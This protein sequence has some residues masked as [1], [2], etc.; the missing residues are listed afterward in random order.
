[1][2]M[3]LNGSFTPIGEGKSYKGIGNY[4]S[5]DEDYKR[6]QNSIRDKMAVLDDIAKHDER[7]RL[8]SI[9]AQ[10]SHNRTVDSLNA[11]LKNIKP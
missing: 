3:L 7:Q 2:T 6:I 4:V 8:L 10:D 5:P 1:M 11:L 9:V